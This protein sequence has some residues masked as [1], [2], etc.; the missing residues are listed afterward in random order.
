MV[1]EKKYGHI[2][3]KNVSK[4]YINL[5]GEENDAV[6]NVS[7]DIKP[8][9][10]V[11]FMGPSGC[12]KTTLLR[13]IAGLLKPDEGQLYLD[14]EEIKGPGY[15]R[16]LVFQ[17]PEL[18]EWLNVEQNVAFGLKARKVYKEQKENV[19]KYID[20]VGLNGF[21]KALP[22][23]LSGGMQQRT[24]FAR[25]LINHPKVLLLDEPTA[26]LDVETSN[27]FCQ[28]LKQLK[29]GPA[30]K[31]GKKRTFLMITHRLE[32][33]KFLAD[34]ILMIEAG[35]IVEYTDCETFFTHPQTQRAAEFLKAQAL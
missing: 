29:G 19:Q 21:E 6:D 33:A 23:H 22:H 27:K 35:H 25:A 9:E 30:A 4:R 11:S 20:M 16:G 12:G 24:A 10:F 32:E 18:F 1:D 34:K 14:G 31:D 15:E 13:I 2:E 5:A 28:T 26:S 8:G 17:N 7:L 3:I